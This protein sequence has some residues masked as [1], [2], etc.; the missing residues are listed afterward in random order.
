MSILDLRANISGQFLNIFFT[1]SGLEI[2]WF[3]ANF[4][5]LHCCTACIFLIL[6][7]HSDPDWNVASWAQIWNEND[8]NDIS[9]FVHGCNNAGNE[10]GN[11]VAL[12]N[13]GND[14]I[15]IAWCQSLLKRHQNREQK[16]KDLKNKEIFC[17]GPKINWI[18]VDRKKKKGN[19]WI[20]QMAWGKNRSIHFIKN[21]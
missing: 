1:I 9:D 7:T 20:F 19:F 5:H 18:H 16:Y 11:L 15:E 10:T 13:G 8:S 12:L 6:H 4:D 21:E 3:Y 2:I 17:K 14:G